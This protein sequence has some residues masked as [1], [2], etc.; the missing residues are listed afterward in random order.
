MRTG[1]QLGVGG[2]YVRSLIEVTAGKPIGVGAAQPLRRVEV[3]RKPISS[4]CRIGGVDGLRG[5][6]AVEPG[7]TVYLTVIC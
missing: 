5:S 3:V 7:T 6:G 1:Q 2:P 4:M